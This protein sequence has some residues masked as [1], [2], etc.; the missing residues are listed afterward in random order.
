MLAREEH[1]ERECDARERRVVLGR[2]RE[3]ILAEVTEKS[4][5]GEEGKEVR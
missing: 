1:R 3:T 5:G 4:E 2:R